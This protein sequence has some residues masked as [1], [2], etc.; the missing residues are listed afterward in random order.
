MLNITVNI[1]AEI[2]AEVSGIVKKDLIPLYP[3]P[4]N[5]RTSPNNSNCG[6]AKIHG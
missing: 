4:E 2:Q 6:T 1:E 3:T 5:E